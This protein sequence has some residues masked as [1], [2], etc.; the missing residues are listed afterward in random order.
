MLLEGGVKSKAADG[1]IHLAQMISKRE[2]PP[3]RAKSLLDGI[4]KRKA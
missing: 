4:L 3:Q 2:A 1:L